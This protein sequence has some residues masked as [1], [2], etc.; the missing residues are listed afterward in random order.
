MGFLNRVKM[1][2]RKQDAHLN[3]MGGPSYRLENP[4]DTLRLAASSSFFGEPMYYQVDRDDTRK[5]R[6]SA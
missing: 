1:K 5:R 3:W 4:L 6:A 2:A